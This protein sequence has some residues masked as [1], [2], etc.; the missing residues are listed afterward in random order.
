MKSI[1]YLY[2]EV[3]PYQVCIYKKLSELGFR[4]NVFFEDTQRQTPYEAPHINNVYYYK[5][6]SFSQD[7]LLRFIDET[8]R[9]SQR[10]D[11]RDRH[12]N[13][14]FGGNCFN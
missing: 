7:N 3:M 6:T 8:N 14:R 10:N 13:V 4:V 11:K 1:I 5:E 2:T 9:L 12:Y